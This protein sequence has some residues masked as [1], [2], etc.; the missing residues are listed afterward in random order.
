ME[1]LKDIA[2]E[3]LDICTVVPWT[4]Q[5]PYEEHQVTTPVPD[6]TCFISPV[7]A[8]CSGEYGAHHKSSSS[9]PLREVFVLIAM[10]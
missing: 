7:T 6:H 1:L 5:M 8:E 2:Q 9:L 3:Q 4:L 10:R